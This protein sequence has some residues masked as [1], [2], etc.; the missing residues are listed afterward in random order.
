MA[1]VTVRNLPEEIHR[2]LRV[3]AAQHGVSTEAEIRAIL[4]TAVAPQ[5]QIKLGSLLA[6]IGA[7]VGGIDLNII[8]DKTV[9]E[10]ISFESGFDGG[11]EDRVE[12][13]P[14]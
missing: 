1:S 14:K 10:P 4:A 5:R 13:A 12:I 11:F 8:R 7:E 2:A 9:T 3:R 6:E